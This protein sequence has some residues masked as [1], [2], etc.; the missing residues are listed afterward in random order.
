VEV[1]ELERERERV[2]TGTEGA[3]AAYALARLSYLCSSTWSRAQAVRH[4]SGGG[5]AELSGALAGAA[6]A[7]AKVEEREGALVECAP[8]ARPDGPAGSSMTRHRYM[9]AR[10]YACVRAPG[11]TTPEKEKAE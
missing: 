11:A 1:S 6:L 10:V 3:R 2:S 4:Q 5:R 7:N 8:G 9:R